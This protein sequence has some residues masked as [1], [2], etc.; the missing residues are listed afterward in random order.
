L[1]E[2][3]CGLYTY[4]ALYVEYLAEEEVVI[5]LRHICRACGE[6]LLELLES[7]GRCVCKGKAVHGRRWEDF[8]R[9]ATA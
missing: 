1:I 7:T 5:G 9:R 3:G 6:L 8:R 4:L 2:L